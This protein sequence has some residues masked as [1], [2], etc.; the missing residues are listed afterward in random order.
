MEP[1][2]RELER[3]L[4]QTLRRQQEIE[5]RL[6][7][8]EQAQAQ[9]GGMATPSTGGAARYYIGKATTSITARSGTTPGSGTVEIYD[10]GSGTLTATGVT[11]TAKNAGTIISSGKWVRIDLDGF[12]VWWASPEEC[13]DE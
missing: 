1:R 2:V 3:L 6:A 5:S 12:G 10:G 7:A 11:K 8:S 4:V 13:E 9:S